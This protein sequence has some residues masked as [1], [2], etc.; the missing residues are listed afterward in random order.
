MAIATDQQRG[1]AMRLAIQQAM[2]Q[3]EASNSHCPKCD[4]ACLHFAAEKR[5]YGKEIQH[6]RGAV[7]KLLDQ[8]SAYMPGDSLQAF[9][10]ALQLDKKQFTLP[11][12]FDTYRKVPFPV[13]NCVSLVDLEKV[14][15]ERDIATMKLATLN[16]E[17]KA[18]KAS[19]AKL[20]EQCASQRPQEVATIREAQQPAEKCV[21]ERPQQ[22]AS[23]PKPA[24]AFELD[25]TDSR[26]GVSFSIGKELSSHT[27]K[28]AEPQSLATKSR[29]TRGTSQPAMR[30][31]GA[32]DFASAMMP[33]ASPKPGFRALPPR[34]PTLSKGRSSQVFV[35]SR[36][37]RA[38][39][40][41]LAFA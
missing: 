41:G 19:N 27:G 10:G 4:E 38:A 16:K 30:S 18:L 5:S 22:A 9:A 28:V 20:A 37:D 29:K 14:T 21:S 12:E 6:L 40:P 15:A 8:L 31:L 35:L 26:L 33:A 25:C 23:K 13:D 39:V 36:D 17:V 2:K 32:V 34:A 1:M 7:Q 24:S 3:V 11:G